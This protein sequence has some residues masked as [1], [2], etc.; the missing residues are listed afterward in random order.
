MSARLSAAIAAAAT[1]CIL[2]PWALAA[3]LGYPPRYDSGYDDRNYAEAYPDAPPP[4]DGE[5][6]VA[7][8]YQ[9]YPPPR[10]VQG[11]GFAEP[12]YPAPRY[13][14]VC[15]R[16]KVVRKRLRRQGWKR[17]RDFRP[18]G[19]VFLVRA[20]Q[21]GTGRPFGLTVDRCS[22][23]VL[24]ARPLFGPPGPYARGPRPYP[25]GRPYY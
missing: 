9:D 11:K 21:R 19:P 20:R 13:A 25:P 22:G 4:Y 23:R 10:A 2:A 18:E 15:V 17:F 12:A 1:F 3:D 16:R 6:V 7:D 24:Q 5:V 14:E 8:G